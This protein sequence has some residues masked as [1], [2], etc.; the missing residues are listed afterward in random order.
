MRSLLGKEAVTVTVHGECMQPL[1][2]DRA[3]L[4][5]TPARCYLPG[6]VVVVLSST[7]T[8]LV[9]RVLGIYWKGGAI[10]ILTRA[11]NSTRPDSAVGLDALLGKV[12]GGSCRPSVVHVPLKHRLTA[13]SRFLCFA[14]ARFARG[15]R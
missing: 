14:A 11:D 1:I 3:Q 2:R 5:V 13:V 8:Y 9:H 4:Q 7:G 6:D 12:S 15:I 10:K